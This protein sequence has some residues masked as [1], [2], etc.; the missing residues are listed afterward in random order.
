MLLEAL[1]SVM[2]SP[3]DK[4]KEFFTRA[5]YLGTEEKWAKYAELHKQPR[6]TVPLIRRGG[7]YGLVRE[8][9]QAFF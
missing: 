6:T 7:A 1:S 5:L 4:R 8:L 3:Y 9:I 2:P